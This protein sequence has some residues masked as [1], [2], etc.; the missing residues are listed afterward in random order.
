MQNTNNP[1]KG[2]SNSLV[3]WEIQIKVTI[4]CYFLSTELDKILIIDSILWWSGYEK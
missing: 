1:I 3:I 2:C 4:K